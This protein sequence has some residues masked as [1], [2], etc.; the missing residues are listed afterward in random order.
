MT[1]YQ[2]D[3][4]RLLVQVVRVMFSGR[5]IVTQLTDTQWMEE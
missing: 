3:N 4:E 2:V 1:E 5:D